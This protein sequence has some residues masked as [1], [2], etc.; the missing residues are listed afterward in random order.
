MKTIS[1]LENWFELDMKTLLETL[2]SETT[3]QWGSMNATQ[4]MDHLSDAFK[5]SMANYAIPADAISEKAEKYKVISLLSDRP[6]PKG[7]NNPILQLLFKTSAP[8]FEQARQALHNQYAA[9]KLYFESNL[10]IQTPHNI[11]GNLHYHEWLWFHYK[12]CL[13]HF[14]QFGLIPYQERIE[15]E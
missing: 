6:L 10:G 9:F 15:L 13:H 4:M 1:Q 7:F 3:P 12:H 5:L 8:E 11:F 2:N 14:A